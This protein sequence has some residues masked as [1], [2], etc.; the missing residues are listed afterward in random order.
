MSIVDEESGSS[1]LSAY[2]CRH[3]GSAVL[4]E[5]PQPCCGEEMESVDVDAVRE[6]EQRV[7]L[8]HVF[9]ISQTGLDICTFLVE[10][11]EA[12]PAEIARALDIDR[13]TVTRQLNQ[14]RELGVMECR[15]ES[16]AEGGRTQ[17]FSPAPMAE[18]RQR[19]REA[20]LSWTAHAISRIEELDEQKLEAAAARERA[21][22]PLDAPAD[23]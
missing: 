18:I 14:L 7:L 3:C 6:P 20:L 15:E 16:L 21:E 5:R 10:Q 19:H 4:E 9:G 13:S 23:E 17:L 11:E 2:S 22:S 12:T 1:R 8:R